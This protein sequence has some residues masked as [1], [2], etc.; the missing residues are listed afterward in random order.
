MADIEQRLGLR[1]SL[2]R[3]LKSLREENGMSQRSV[4]EQLG[5]DASTLSRLEAGHSNWHLETFVHYSHVVGAN[6]GSILTQVLQQLDHED[7]ASL[8]ENEE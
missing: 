8:W 5:L 1:R 6:P 3:H 7:P 4:S 2:G